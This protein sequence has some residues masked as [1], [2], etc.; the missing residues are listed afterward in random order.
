MRSAATPYRYP[1]HLR[2]DAEAMPKAAG[3]YVFHGEDGPLPLYVGKSVCLRT[4]VLDHLRTPE[5]ARMLHQA[6]RITSQRT[7][8]DVGAQ[9]L[10]SH[11][12]KRLKPIYNR[13]LRQVKTLYSLRL[14]EGRVTVVSS[15]DEAF[16]EQVGVHGLFRTAPAARRAIEELA[17][18]HR[19]CL[20]T[21]GMEPGTAG[22]PCFRHQI[23]RCA[24][25]CAGAD[26]A[27]G[28]QQ[29]TSAA[30]ESLRMKRWPYRGALGV[31]ER[32]GRMSR[33]HVVREWCYL[34]SAATPAAAVKLA[35]RPAR[36][37]LD[38]YRLLAPLLVT[39]GKVQTLELSS[40]TA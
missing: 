9:L 8:G 10:E 34:G 5:E 16:S 33:I 2:G 21:L 38:G 14:A 28:H 11:L 7:A 25:A 26:D 31:V 29:R 4:R 1:D 30:L 19:L 18:L 40:C 39:P 24:G 13:R 23:R 3:V 6:R 32:E 22:R 12:V 17:D 27:Y 35:N 15:A 36:F 37:D 20:V